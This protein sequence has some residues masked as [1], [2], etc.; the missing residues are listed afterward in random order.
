M[1]K[2]ELLAQGKFL[3]ND[4]MPKAFHISVNLV[5]RGN[6][7]DERLIAS[8]SI[9]VEEL[10]GKPLMWFDPYLDMLG[11]STLKIAFAYLDEATLYILVDDGNDIKLV[12]KECYLHSFS[13]DYDNSYIIASSIW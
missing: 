6:F 11:G 10:V 4:P 2:E 3:V 1:T 8:R 12:E 5:Y 7:N 13:D 9:E